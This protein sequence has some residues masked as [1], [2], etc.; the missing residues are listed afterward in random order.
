MLQRPVMVLDVVVLVEE[1]VWIGVGGGG[2]DGG[3]NGVGESL[4]ASGPRDGWGGGSRKEMDDAEGREE[5]VGA[6]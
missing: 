5:G 4:I 2:G 6:L 3:R 1:E